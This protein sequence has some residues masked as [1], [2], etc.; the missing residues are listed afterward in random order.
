MRWNTPSRALACVM[1]NMDLMRPLGVAG[2]RYVVVT[3]SQHARIFTLHKHDDFLARQGD[4]GR[5]R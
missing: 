5:G 2:I 4:R 1:G 3:A